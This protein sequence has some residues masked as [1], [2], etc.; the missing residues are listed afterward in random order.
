MAAGAGTL[1]I[2]FTAEYGFGL[3]PC[4]LCLTQRVPFYA[5]LGLGLGAL[6]FPALR[7]QLVVLA[8]VG[9]LVNSGIAVYHVGVEQHWWS[10]VTGCGGGDVTAMSFSDMKKSL[11][12]KTLKA[13]D[14][15]DWT[16]F[17][18]SFATYNIFYSFALGVVTVYAAAL[19][20]REPS[21]NG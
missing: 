14:E 8:G 16:L 21:N 9:F 11:G 1:A 12:Q 13:C 6:A 18:I 5:A 19:L 2:A 4:I 17:G 3:E 20:K 10:S 7:W 15:V